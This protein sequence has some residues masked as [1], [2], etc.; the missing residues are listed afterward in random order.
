LDEK[1]EEVGAEEG[2]RAGGGDGKTGE[3]KEYSVKIGGM[4]TLQLRVGTE[5]EGVVRSINESKE[6]LR[7]VQ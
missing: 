6:Q 4:Q 7:K 5:V 1:K 2:E 3:Q